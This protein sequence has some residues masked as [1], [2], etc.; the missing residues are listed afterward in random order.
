[1][2]DSLIYFIFVSFSAITECYDVVN[3]LQCQFNLAHKQKRTENVL[4]G[5]QMRKKF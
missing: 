1:M 2:C 5:S 4:N 3:D